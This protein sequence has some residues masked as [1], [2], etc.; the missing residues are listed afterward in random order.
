MAKSFD[1]IL[2]DVCIDYILNNANPELATHV[3][4]V[5]T[6]VCALEPRAADLE[7]YRNGG[8]CSL[9]IL[10]R[11]FPLQRRTPLW[12]AKCTSC[13]F[14]LLVGEWAGPFL[15]HETLTVQGNWE[16]VKLSEVVRLANE[17]N[18]M[19]DSIQNGTM[20]TP[21]APTDAD[22]DVSMKARVASSTDA[23]SGTNG[24][25]EKGSNRKRRR[26]DYGT[27]TAPGGN[28]F[29]HRMGSSTSSPF[30]RR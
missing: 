23:L 8:P 20:V 3:E 6:L 30:I 5:D 4:A 12:S 22:A 2:A 18:A 13:V 28:P 7:P 16:I 29:D 9:P 11:S 24:D 15:E 21:L 1:K 17:R 10:C 26:T 27:E 14:A 19:L 25:S